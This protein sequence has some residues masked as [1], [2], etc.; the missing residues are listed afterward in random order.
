MKTTMMFILA[1]VLLLAAVATAW[2][3][4]FI[5]HSA[6]PATETGVDRDRSVLR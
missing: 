6:P 2:D 4:S 3:V 5:A 1:M